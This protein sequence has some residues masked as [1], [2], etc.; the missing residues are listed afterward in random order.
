MSRSRPPL[1]SLHTWLEAMMAKMSRKSDVALA[2]NYT[3]RITA[4]WKWTTTPR[5][6]ALRAVALEG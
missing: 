4:A 3:A 5:S 1:E 6:D 2:L